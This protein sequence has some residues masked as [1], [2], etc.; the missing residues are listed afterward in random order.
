MQKWKVWQYENRRKISVVQIQPAFICFWPPQ[1]WNRHLY[2]LLRTFGKLSSMRGLVDFTIHHETKQWDTSQKIIFID[3][4]SDGREGFQLM[5]WG[6]GWWWWPPEPEPVTNHRSRRVS[7]VV[8]ET[9]WCWVTGER[10]SS[11]ICHDL[12]SAH[13]PG[14]ADQQT[15]KTRSIDI[16]IFVGWREHLGYWVKVL[17]QLKFG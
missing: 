11:A 9:I 6:S 2:L 13:Y 5:A 3:C 10:R 1:L 15:K 8:T 17:L 12:E 7:T 16:D 4:G 14:R